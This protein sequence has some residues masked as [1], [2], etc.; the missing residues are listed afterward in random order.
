MKV[1]GMV[2]LLTTICVLNVSVV[3]ADGSIYIRADGSVDPPTAPI[4]CD[5]NLYTFTDD[6]VNQ[7]IIVERDNIIVNGKGYTLQGDGTGCGIDLSDRNSVVVQNVR[8]TGFSYGIFLGT[9]LGCTV[10]NCIYNNHIKNTTYGVMLLFSHRNSICDNIITNC[11]TGIFLGHSHRNN[12]LKNDITNIRTDCIM[13]SCSETN[14]VAGNNFTGSLC[15][16]SLEFSGART[17]PNTFH[18]NNF[19]N[20]TCQ[21]CAFPDPLYIRWDYGYPS[22]GNYWSDY[23]G[24]DTYSGPYQNET[25][26]DGIGDTPYAVYEYGVD[27]YP[28]MKPWHSL[29]GDVNW[30]RTVNIQDIVLIASIYGCAKDDPD[31][32]PLA[33]LAPEWGKIDIYDLVTCAAHYGQTRP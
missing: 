31:W 20:N 9:E 12:I 26:S 13:L 21:V 33:D 27:P 22:G 7:R 16:I 2:L 23:S 10:S 14:I 15:G 30:D 19:I 4:E 6:I 5:G 25:G 17:P 32:N 3:R 29:P 8:I 1:V 24:N 11:D 28:L 18:H